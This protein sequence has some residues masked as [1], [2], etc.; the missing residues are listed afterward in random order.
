MKNLTLR[1]KIESYTGN[2]IEANPAFLR[3]MSL[4]EA[5]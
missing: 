5:L 2:K 4:Q 3:T 1:E